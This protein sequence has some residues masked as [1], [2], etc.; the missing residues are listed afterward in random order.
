MMV[1]K[2]AANIIAGAVAV[3]YAASAIWLGF[4]I[5]ENIGIYLVFHHAR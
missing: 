2:T 1:N 4:Y 3:A 5:A